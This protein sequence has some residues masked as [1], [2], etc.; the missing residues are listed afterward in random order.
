MFKEQR[1]VG[2]HWLNTS[3]NDLVRTLVEKGSF[4][5]REQFELLLQ[6]KSIQKPLME[7]L[8]F[9]DLENDEEAVWSLLLYAGYLTV[10]S[11]TRGEFELLGQVVVPNKEVMYIYDKIIVKWFKKN[12]SLSSYKDFVGALIA[13]NIEFLGYTSPNI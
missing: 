9:P 12:E 5:I 10:L 6:G 2:P 4:R 8:I 1:E 11:S 3:S 13:G 7:N